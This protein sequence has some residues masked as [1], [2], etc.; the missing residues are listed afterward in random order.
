MLVQHYEDLRGRAVKGPIGG[1]RR[2]LTVLIRDGMA[3]WM[4]LCA[5]CS[6]PTTKETRTTIEGRECGLENVESEVVDVLAN[7]ALNQ[8]KEA[9]I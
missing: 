6:S 1:P 3:A 9:C 8:L 4:E 7:M 2:G 5:Q